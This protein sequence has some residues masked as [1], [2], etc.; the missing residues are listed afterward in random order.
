VRPTDQTNRNLS[1]G[2]FYQEDPYSTSLA[3]PQRLNKT[4]DFYTQ[5]VSIGLAARF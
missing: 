1:K 5:G 2:Q 4:T 3:Y